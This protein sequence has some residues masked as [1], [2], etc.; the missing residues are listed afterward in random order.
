MD[1]WINW[2][3]SLWQLSYTKWECFLFNRALLLLLHGL[4][5][6]TCSCHYST[7]WN[8]TYTVTNSYC[9]C[10][11]FDVKYLSGFCISYLRDLIFIQPTTRPKL[12]HVDSEDKTEAGNMCNTLFVMMLFGKWFY[13]YV[14]YWNVWKSGWLYSA[15]V[16]EKWVTQPTEIQPVPFTDVELSLQHQAQLTR[17]HYQTLPTVSIQLFKSLHIMQGYIWCFPIFSTFYENNK[18]EINS[19]LN[20]LWVCWKYKFIEL[21]RTHFSLD[22]HALFSL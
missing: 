11:C 6:F 12:L 2:T 3:G 15:Q 4:N 8:I 21:L 16:L 22:L 10:Y 5:H 14:N 9:C 18:T 7:Y 1:G 20:C 13:Y 19:A 17:L